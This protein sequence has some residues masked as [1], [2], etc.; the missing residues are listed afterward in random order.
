M[1]D[2][3]I[4][5][6]EEMQQTLNAYESARENMQQAF[7]QL[8][9][10]KDALDACWEGPAKLAYIARWISIHTN[11]VKSNE[12]IQAAVEGLQGTIQTQDT[13]EQDVG[14]KASGLYVGTTPPD[15]F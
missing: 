4:V 11:L 3:I 2:R 5:S 1:A 13:A 12:A 9:A 15:V 6:T 7:S 10:A 8:E 14:S